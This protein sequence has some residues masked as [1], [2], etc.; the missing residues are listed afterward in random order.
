MLVLSGQGGVWL[1]GGSAGVFSA[2]ACPLST[3]G[4]G[5]PGWLFAG[6]A[7]TAVSTVGSICPCMVGHIFLSTPL[8][9]KPGAPALGFGE[10]LS[11]SHV[12]PYPAKVD[13]RVGGW[14]PRGQQPSVQR[15]P[16]WGG[17]HRGTWGW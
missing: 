3:L 12:C 5:S 2:L 13:E 16:A 8:G 4:P 14:G 6:I 17:D 9:A 11:M 1:V 15:Y 7:P 10:P